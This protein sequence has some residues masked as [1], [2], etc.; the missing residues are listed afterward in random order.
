MLKRTDIPSPL[1]RRASVERLQRVREG[2]KVV[3]ASGDD[4][5]TVAFV[6]MGNWEAENDPNE[7]DRHSGMVVAAL[8]P[9]GADASGRP[10]VAMPVGPADDEFGEDVPAPVRLRLL[11]HGYVRISGRFFFG[12][13]RY[14]FADQIATVGEDVVRLC[15]YKDALAI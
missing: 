2:M 14:V 8:A 3:D 10:I 9:S 13:D 4:I 6:K 7:T 12:K 5:G 15:V 11:Q 1:D